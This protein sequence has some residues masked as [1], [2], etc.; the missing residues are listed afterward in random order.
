LYGHGLAEYELGKFAKG[1]RNEVTIV[2]KFGIW[3]DTLFNSSIYF[4][5]LRMALSRLPGVPRVSPPT[6][7]FNPRKLTGSVEN[8]L[9]R[10][11]TDYIDV[12]VLH[13]PAL[14]EL[15]QPEELAALLISL[16]QAGKIR[17]FGLSAPVDSVI[18]I[19]KV[20]PSLCGF[21]QIWWNP[22]QDMASLLATIDRK[23]DASFG[24][25]HAQKTVNGTFAMGNN[26]GR[27]YLIKQA[28]STNPDGVV[29][30]ST[31]NTDHLNETVED[32]V[33]QENLQGS[34]NKSGDL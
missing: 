19:S 18:A 14:H 1:R 24:H 8:S 29:L 10:L 31:R 15:T 12:L 26:S 22:D 2:T 3:P 27:N 4:Y 25:F 6:R 32:F 17:A 20:C 11:G 16:K 5:Y 30:F 33:K 23:P 7:D 28:I 21:L 9:R 13:E 34:I